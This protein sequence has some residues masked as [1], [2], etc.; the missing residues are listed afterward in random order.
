MTVVQA[1]A[2][3][4]PMP[5]GPLVVFMANPFG[6]GTMRRVLEQ[7]VARRGRGEV[8]IVYSNPVHADVFDA[9]PALTVHDRGPDWAVH[10]LDGPAVPA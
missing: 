3:T 6:A 7:V 2:A 9:Y 8:V 5:D 1:D 10:E 4:Y